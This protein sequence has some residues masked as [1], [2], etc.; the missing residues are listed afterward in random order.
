PVLS[1]VRLNILLKNRVADIPG[2]RHSIESLWAAVQAVWE[3]I[4]D[5]EVAMHTSRM[6]DRVRAVR[7]AKGWNTIF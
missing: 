1:P 4:T 7:K 2:S 3:G 6:G 5:N